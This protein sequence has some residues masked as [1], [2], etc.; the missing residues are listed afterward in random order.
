[1]AEGCTGAISASR[2][3][4]M[5]K[6]AGRKYSG[7][8][9]RNA[10]KNIDRL[11]NDRKEESNKRSGEDILYSLYRRSRSNNSLCAVKS[12]DACC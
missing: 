12:I 4:A 11:E 1:M 2:S 7:A 3:L 5:G 6:F 10:G 9:L 8:F